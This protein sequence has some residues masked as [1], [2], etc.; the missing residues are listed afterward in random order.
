MSDDYLSG[1]TK[2]CP[3]CGSKKELSQFYKDKIKDREASTY[4][5]VCTKKINT[6]NYAIHHEKRRTRAQIYFQRTKRARVEKRNQQH[7][8]M[9]SKFLFVYGGRCSCCG[10]RRSEFLTV[11]HVNGQKKIKK[12]TS[13]SAY[14]N[15]IKEYPSKNYDI[16]CVNCN[17]ARGRYG[18]C[19][20][21][22]E[23]Q[24]CSQPA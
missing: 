16:L 19:P 3:S 15:A 8:D 20:H 14:S 24:E 23:R 22:K 11:E 2:T 6:R 1:D 13:Y 4:C 5:K 9:R 7:R 21:E 12:E 17:H 18:V 10:E